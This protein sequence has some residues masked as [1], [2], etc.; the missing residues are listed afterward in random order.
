MSFI[1]SIL[2][3]IGAIQG[4]TYTQHELDAITNA[5]QAEINVIQNDAMLSTTVVTQTN[6]SVVTVV[7][8]GQDD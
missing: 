3:W 7:V 1:I 6:P 8:P 2:L 5:H 4:G